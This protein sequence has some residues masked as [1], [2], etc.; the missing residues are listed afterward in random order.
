[1]QFFLDSADVQQIAELNAIGLVD[2]ITTNPTILAKANRPYLQIVKEICGLVAGP[3]S[4]EVIAPDHATM[5]KEALVIA[6]LAENVV[7]K[8][9]LTPAGLQTCHELTN[10]GIPTN[11][12]LCFSAAQALLAAKAGATFVSPFIGRL[13][14]V[15]Q[16]GLEL[17]ADIRAIFDQYPDLNTA[18][19]AASI[20]H[21]IHVIEAAK[22]GA[23][24]A[25]MPPNVLQQMFQHPLT[26]RGLEQFNADWAKTG[27]S[28]LAAA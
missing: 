20:R 22:L 7:V 15:G 8:L 9:P 2:G 12:T 10:R 1:M 18:I 28:I 26:D 11:V 25:T 16:N 23:D 13:D 17:I 27:Q 21:P 6:E 19:L 24:V 3:V 14:D 5:L 4:V